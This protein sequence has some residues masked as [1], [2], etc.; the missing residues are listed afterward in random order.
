MT[1]TQTEWLEIA[2]MR[3]G[4]GRLD[5]LFKFHSSVVKTAT[6]EQLLRAKALEALGNAEAS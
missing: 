1:K 3:R 6:A 5:A 4:L 2:E